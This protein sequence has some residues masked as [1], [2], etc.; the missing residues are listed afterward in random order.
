MSI[1]YMKD[2]RLAQQIAPPWLTYRRAQGWE[3][4]YVVFTNGCFDLFTPGHEHLLQSIFLLPEISNKVSIRLVVG[5]N[6]DAS[7]RR[8][9]GSS[10]P[11]FPEWHRARIVQRWDEPGVDDVIIFDGDT[12]DELI[13]MIDPD[14]IVKG[15]DYTPDAVRTGSKK[16][17][18]AIVRTLPGWSTTEIA[19]R[20]RK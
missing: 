15:G 18:V 3:Q 12:P 10:R 9:K 4:A 20:L 5:I 17:P 16:R 2:L 13:D 11:L 8:L 6:D 19:E 14:L 7:V 1:E